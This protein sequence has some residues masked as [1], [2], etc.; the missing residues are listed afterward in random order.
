VAAGAPEAAHA[1]D[2]MGQ[3]RE[4]AAGRS[5]ERLRAGVE[6]I[7]QWRLR[8]AVNVSEELALEGLAY[9]LQDLLST[10]P[11]AGASSERARRLSDSRSETMAAR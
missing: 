5:P 9:T 1:V 3:L 2:R 10:H 7:A 4:D 8:L 6:A 11:T